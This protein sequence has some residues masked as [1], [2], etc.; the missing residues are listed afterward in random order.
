MMTPKEVFGFDADGIEEF[1]IEQFPIFNVPEEVFHQRLNTDE[2]PNINTRKRLVAPEG[3][4]LETY[5]QNAEDNRPF[6]LKYADG[7]EVYTKKVR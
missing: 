2:E 1:G 5:L 3:S 4:Y 7:T 6:V